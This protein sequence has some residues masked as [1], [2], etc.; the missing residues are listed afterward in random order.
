MTTVNADK[1]TWTLAE[2]L[3]AKYTALAGLADALEKAV[4][5][6]EIETEQEAARFVRQWAAAVASMVP[7]TY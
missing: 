1:A 6:G 7:A 5:L 4:D 3:E 2:V